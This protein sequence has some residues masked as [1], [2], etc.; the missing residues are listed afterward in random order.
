VI[1]ESG[2]LLDD[3]GQAG[4]ETLVSPLAVIRRSLV[5]PT[6]LAHLARTWAANA[7]SLA[8]LIRARRIALVHSNTSVLLGGAAAAGLARVPHVWHVREI[9]AGF[10]RWW[11]AHRR[12]LLSAA[13]L[14]CVSEATRA[15]FGSHPRPRVIHDGVALPAPD[16][17]RLRPPRGLR[18]KGSAGAEATR[19]RWGLE[20]DAFVCAVLGRLSDW[21]GQDV[22]IRAL[23]Q[24]PLQTAGAIGL[25]AGEPWQGRARTDELLELARGLGVAERV[26]LLGF[27]DDPAALYAATDVVVVPST[28][29]DPLPNAAL[30]AAASGCCVVASALGGLPEIISDGR[31]GR[32]VAPGDPRALAG[33]LAELAADPDAR[34]RLGT[35]AAADVSAR[36][37]P[38]RM[39][40]AVQALYDELLAG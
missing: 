32:L 3:L 16:F 10:E 2:P 37:S 28:R 36:F 24:P 4:V 20:P 12:L 38:G 17:E 27:V 9:Y 13:A 26:R 31:T 22:L 1:P 40:E 25:I 34:R 11:P 33:A 23:A 19:A 29:P 30:E 7:A 21:K 8:R 35:A 14:P 18:R 39:L 6:G 15:Q 5:T